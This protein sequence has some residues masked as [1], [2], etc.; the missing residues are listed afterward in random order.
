MGE[1]SA[2]LLIGTIASFMTSARTRRAL[3]AAFL[4]APFLAQCTGSDLTRKLSP[5]KVATSTRDADRAAGLISQ[6]RAAHG[7]GPVRVSA[8]L[9]QAALYQ[10]RAV[11]E[12]GTLSHGS[13]ASRMG[14]FGIGGV[15]AENLSAGSATV[16][17]AIARWKGSPG[18]N[19][20]LLMAE[21]RSIG[22]ARADSPRNGYE[23]YW[24]LVLG[25]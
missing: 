7:L 11:A 2:H 9:N 17:G 18:H 5:D 15:S 6:Y 13:F 1:S 10:A 24:A 12:A 4:V 8:Q 20:N 25:Q 22:L 3:I 23:H 19:E 21:A 16:E 14:T